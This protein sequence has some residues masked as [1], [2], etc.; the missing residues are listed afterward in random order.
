MVFRCQPKQMVHI[1]SINNDLF[2]EILS[3]SSVI[4]AVDV[5]TRYTDRIVNPLDVISITH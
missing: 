5:Y 3:N 1:T 4:L 2:F